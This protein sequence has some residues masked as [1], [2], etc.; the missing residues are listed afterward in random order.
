MPF[1]FSLV[2]SPRRLCNGVM[3]RLS[4]LHRFSVLK[5]FGTT[6]VSP[7]E[8]FNIIYKDENYSVPKKNYIDTVYDLLS[9]LQL[10]YKD[11][12]GAYQTSKM[13][14]FANGSELKNNQEIKDFPDEVAC[15]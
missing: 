7:I 9:A 13:M 4:H 10:R 2:A 5:N 15:L 6:T 3:Q 11:D 12:F 8:H 1:T 14:L